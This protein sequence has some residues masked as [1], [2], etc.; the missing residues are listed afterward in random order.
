MSIDAFTELFEPADIHVAQRLTALGKDDDTRVALAVALAVRALRS[1]SVCVDLR[2][3]ADQI[4]VQ[5]QHL[6]RGQRAGPH[7]RR[8]LLR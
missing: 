1:G 4:A 6:L 8:P 2:A 5:A 7:R 3:V